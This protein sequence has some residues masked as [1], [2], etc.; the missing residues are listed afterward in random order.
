MLE[1]EP[2][3]RLWQ[4]YLLFLKH[5]VK[6]LDCQQL[7]CIDLVS[8]ITNHLLWILFSWKIDKHYFCTNINILHILFSLWSPYFINILNQS[9]KWCLYCQL[10]YRDNKTRIVDDSFKTFLNTSLVTSFISIFTITSLVFFFFFLC[11]I[12][13]YA[14]STTV[15]STIISLRVL[16]W[17]TFSLFHYKSNQLS[18][19]LDVLENVSIKFWTEK[20]KWSECCV[21]IT[22]FYTQFTLLSEITVFCLSYFLYENMNNE[23]NNYNY[24]PAK[25]WGSVFLYSYIFAHFFVYF[26][27]SFFFFLISNSFK[28]RSTHCGSF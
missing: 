22:F 11:R 21:C 26:V 14:I 17:N 8:N 4:N 7:C 10:N 18:S 9:T 20:M 24:T 28:I 13:F 15:V 16:R 6:R 2:A 1:K 5:N 23:L 19:S 25:R 27:F 12:T 3:L